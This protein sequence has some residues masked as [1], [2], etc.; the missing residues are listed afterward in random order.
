MLIERFIGDQF[1]SLED[2]LTDESRVVRIS[3]DADE[4]ERPHL[5]CIDQQEELHG[6]FLAG[7]Y[8]LAEPGVVSGRAAPE[9]N[10]VM[11]AALK[12]S[13]CV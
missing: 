6:G 12:N 9:T 3:T 1:V 11:D 10:E 7:K 2:T 13:T 4:G 5:R 8:V